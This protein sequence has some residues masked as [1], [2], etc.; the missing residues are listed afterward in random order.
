MKILLLGGKSDGKVMDIPRFITPV[1]TYD[2]PVQPARFG[3]KF[4]ETVEYQIVTYHYSERLSPQDTTLPCVFVSDIIERNSDEAALLLMHRAIKGSL[5]A[6]GVGCCGLSLY[7]ERDV[8]D[9]ETDHAIR[10]LREK[11]SNLRERGPVHLV[12]PIH[13]DALGF[14]E[15]A[16]A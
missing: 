6:T 10:L 16:Q 13:K 11:A 5:K 15:P 9:E 14:P 1:Q 7:I 8:Y 3:E 12:N 4:D 2:M